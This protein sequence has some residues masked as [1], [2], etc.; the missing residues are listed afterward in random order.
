MPKACERSRVSSICLRIFVLTVFPWL[1]LKG[2][3]RIYHYWT[4]SFVSSMGLKQM[5]AVLFRLV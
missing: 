1:V 2:I 5:E 3:D 4:Y